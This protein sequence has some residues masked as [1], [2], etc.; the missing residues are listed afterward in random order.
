MG[1]RPRRSVRQ[2]DDPNFSALLKS[3]PPVAM[4]YQGRRK[5]G[6]GFIIIGCLILLALG[7]FVR[8][9]LIDPSRAGREGERA[10]PVR[11][12]AHSEMLSKIRAQGS[13]P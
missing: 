9:A 8:A 6:S 12:N 7:A 1:F 10:S 2:S 5:G 3:R 11:T 4:T 13:R